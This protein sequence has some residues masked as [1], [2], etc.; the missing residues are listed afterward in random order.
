MKTRDK[1]HR[2]LL[3]RESGP[4]FNDDSLSRRD[5]LRRGLIYGGIV[6]VSP[7]VL[8]T[9]GCGTVT[10]QSFVKEAA[11]SAMPWLGWDRK[12]L[13]SAAFSWLAKRY[14]VPLLPDVEDVRSAAI[15]LANRLGLKET[16]RPRPTG[17]SFHDSH[18]ENYEVT[19]RRYYREM[20]SRKIGCCVK[21]DRYLR[22]GES[23]SVAH[24]GDLSASELKAMAVYD[25]HRQRVIIP[26]G[27]RKSLSKSERKMI[28]H[29]LLTSKL[30]TS[31]ATMTIPSGKWVV[32]YVRNFTY[33]G[34]RIQGYG[35]IREAN[36]ERLFCLLA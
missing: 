4:A 34:S 17:N 13:V 1:L 23:M 21:L 11:L 27:R 20:F 10:F 26:D 32:Q 18:A 24:F 15:E 28:A 14:V 5:F 16:N 22:C 30:Y 35:L 9:Q 31:A 36:K 29:T 3:V 19:N 25:F 6:T 7:L 2:S 12:E 33:R 8:F